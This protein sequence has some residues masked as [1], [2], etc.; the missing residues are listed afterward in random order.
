MGKIA[1]FAGAG[2]NDNAWHL[3]RW[4]LAMFTSRTALVFHNDAPFRVI[5]LVSH[6]F[7]DKT[8]FLAKVYILVT[9]L[10]IVTTKI[11]W[12]RVVTG[13]KNDTNNKG[14]KDANRN[15]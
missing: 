2:Q 6:T 11:N 5:P 3:R 12:L 4:V 1:L 14:C 9:P 15:S 8:I 13:E 7:C 10:S